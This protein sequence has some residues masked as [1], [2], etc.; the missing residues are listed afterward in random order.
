MEKCKNKGKTITIVKAVDGKVFGGY[1][2]L[3]FNGSG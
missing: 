1:T 3:N 2:D